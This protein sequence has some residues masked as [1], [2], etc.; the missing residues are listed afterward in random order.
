MHHPEFG[1]KV[2]PTVDGRIVETSGM[3]LHLY[4]DTA[5]RIAVSPP[6]PAER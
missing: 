4:D 6:R 1:I 2:A 3:M 5:E